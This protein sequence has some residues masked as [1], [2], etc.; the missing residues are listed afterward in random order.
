MLKSITVFFVHAC[1]LTHAPK[2]PAHQ[3]SAHQAPH[4]PQTSPPDLLAITLTQH[5]YAT[6]LLLTLLLPAWVCLQHCHQARGVSCKCADAC[7][8]LVVCCAIAC[9][10]PAEGALWQHSPVVLAISCGSGRCEGTWQG[11]LARCQL[12]QQGRG[13][14]HAVHSRQGAD[15]IQHI[16]ACAAAPGGRHADGGVTKLAEIRVHG[17]SSHDT[18]VLCRGEA[19]GPLGVVSLDPL[20]HTSREGG[21]EGSLGL[22][23]RHR[24]A[25][26]KHQ[27]D[28][29][30][31]AVT[32][33][34]LSAA[35]ALPGAR[36][37]DEDACAAHTGSL[38]QGDD[39]AGARLGCCCVEGQA[40]VDLGGDVAGNMGQDLLAQVDRQVVNG[41]GDGISG[42]LGSGGFGRRQ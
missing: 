30:L 29:G 8:H 23:C 22:G 31:D 10:L 11:L 5:M 25:D 2:L 17:T 32:L 14:C 28:V 3:G 41:K 33:Q 6:A 27:G 9:Q 16:G 38:V 35:D 7:C 1:A 18:R 21:D 4:V 15:L 12:L 13:D 40:D 34:G 39:A 26:P 42:G 36:K 19:L 24:L 20:Q 37:L